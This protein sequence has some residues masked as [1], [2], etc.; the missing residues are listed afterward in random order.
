MLQVPLASCLPF[1]IIDPGGWNRVRQAR[2]SMLSLHSV[3]LTQSR[4]VTCCPT[5]TCKNKNKKCLPLPAAEAMW[6]FVNSVG[7]GGLGWTFGEYSGSKK[8]SFNSLMQTHPKYEQHRSKGQSLHIKETE[9]NISQS[10]EQL[11][12]QVWVRKGSL[13]SWIL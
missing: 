1:A 11:P 13:P 12:V 7:L 9:Q 4:S 2:D 5:G 3:L 10:A 6:S 8:K